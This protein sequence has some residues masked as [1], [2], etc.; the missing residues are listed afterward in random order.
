MLCALLLLMKCLKIT[1]PLPFLPDISS[2]GH[3]SDMVRLYVSVS[4][5]ENSLPV[6]IRYFLFVSQKVKKVILCVDVVLFASFQD[7]IITKL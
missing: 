2:N 5:I 3:T 4:C 1:F 6:F 7:K